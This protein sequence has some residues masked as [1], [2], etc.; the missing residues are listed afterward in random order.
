[1]RPTYTNI[2]C[3]PDGTGIFLSVPRFKWNVISTT[4]HSRPLSHTGGLL[5]TPCWAA[6]I[7]LDWRNLLKSSHS[8]AAG[9]SS[10]RGHRAAPSLSLSLFLFLLCHPPAP[11][12]LSLFLL[13]SFSTLSCASHSLFSPPFPC[14]LFFFFPPHPVSLSSPY[15]I[16]VFMRALGLLRYRL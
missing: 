6:Q 10:R 4:V 1:M 3:I 14:L 11:P 12:S 16:F 8:Q 5:V 7:P 13:S 2:V 9:S 15:W